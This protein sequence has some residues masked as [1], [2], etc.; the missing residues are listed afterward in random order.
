MPQVA[1]AVT[2]YNKEQR[3]PNLL[4]PLTEEQIEERTFS[5]D[6]V[7]ELAGELKPGQV[8]YVELDENGTPSGAATLEPPEPGHGVYARVVATSPYKL[9]EVTTPSGAP[10]T[11]HMQPDPTLW[12]EGMLERNPPGGNWTPPKGNNDRPDRKAKRAQHERTEHALDHSDGQ[13]A[14]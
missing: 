1:G 11:K 9:D 12:D 7:K 5:A 3:D 2:T 10:V 13:K 8:G 4:L 14:T 6:E